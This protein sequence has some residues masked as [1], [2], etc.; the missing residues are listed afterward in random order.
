[1]HSMVNEHLCVVCDEACIQAQRLI[2][3]RTSDNGASMRFTGYDKIYP[4]FVYGQTITLI[5]Y[6]DPTQP[7]AVQQDN[8]LQTN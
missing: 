4:E 7:V 1:M 5:S 8:L 3:E 2:E 6:S